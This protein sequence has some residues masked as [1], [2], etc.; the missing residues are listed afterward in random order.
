V[1]GNATKA[2]SYAGYFVGD[3]NVSEKVLSDDSGDADMKAY[4]Y[5]KITGTSSGA[6]IVST[7]SS[8][9]YSIT[10]AAEGEYNVTFTNSPGSSSAYIVMTSFDRL[11]GYN[12]AISTVNYSSYFKIYTEVQTGLGGLVSHDFNFSF[13]VYKK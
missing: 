13:V 12:P 10:R 2:G 7:A 5:G 1:Y 3:V 8:G 6:S 9:G 4:I 11:E